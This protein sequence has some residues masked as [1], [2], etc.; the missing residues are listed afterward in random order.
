[1]G[2]QIDGE[3]ENEGGILLRG[4]GAKGLQIAELNR[5]GGFVYHV[6][7]FFQG[8]GGLLLTLGCNYL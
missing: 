8:C 4:N 5:E 6:G 3:R 1:M 7:G 2:Y